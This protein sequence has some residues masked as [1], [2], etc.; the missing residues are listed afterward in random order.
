MST[1][2]TSRQRVENF[3]NRKP[4]DSR[5][6][7]S[8]MGMVTKQAVDKTG[9]RFAQIHV[10]AKN[11]AKTAIATAEMYGFDSVVV[12]YD[13]CTV[14]EAL[15]RGISIYEESEDILYPT[16]P[17][18]WNDIDQIEIPTDYLQ[19]G[20]LPL[21]DDAIKIMKKQV[22][23]RIAV[24]GWVLGP[25]T[26][27]GQIYELDLLLKGLK[28]NK[29]KIDD[30]LTRLT[31]LTIEMARHYQKLGCDYIT[32]RE[33]GTGT[34]LLSPRM[35]K[36]LIKPNLERVMA[37]LDSPKILHICGSTDMIF[38]MMND[39][40][41]DALSVDQKNTLAAS[42]E[43]CGDATLLLGNFDPYNTLCQCETKEVAPI[44]NQCLIDGADAV[45]PGCDIWPDV[46][47]GNI[48]AFVETAS[49]LVAAD[50][51]NV[52]KETETEPARS[53]A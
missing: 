3:F 28:K 40:G 47:E 20:R 27:A 30:L 23:D 14:A 22:G 42:K 52:N 9:I 38:E 15:G 44:I 1:T 35:W 13:M 25:F 4:T 34:D 41:A 6:C 32:V 16:I 18:K 24:G 48:E 29:E 17:N 7:F 36:T 11:M 49:S 10:S 50:M 43:I 12:P 46:K 31:D 8:G 21:V 51:R 26:L 37:A 53:E 2:M 19:Q 39:C 33:M 45:W 5:P